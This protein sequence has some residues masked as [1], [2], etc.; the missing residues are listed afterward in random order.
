M[1]KMDQVERIR[2][3]VL[4]KGLSERQAARECRVSR[5]LVRRALGDAE[6]PKYHLSKP[7]PRP[8]LDAVRALVEEMLR[9]DA[10]QPRKQ[11]HTARRIFHR[12]REEH[13]FQGAESSIRRCVA[14]LRQRQPEVFVPLAYDAGSEAQVDF[15]E[16]E[17]V[18]A[19]QRIT[20]Q[21]FCIKL[22]YSHMPFVIAFPHQRQ[23][24]FF[25]GHREAFAFFGGV[26]RRLTYDNLKVAVQ[27]ILEGHDREEQAAFQSLRAHYLF[28]SHFCNPRHG[29]EK[30]QVESLVGYVRRNALVPVPEV[31]SFAELNAHLLRWCEREAERTQPGMTGTIGE[32]LVADRAALLPLPE[33][34]FDCARVVMAKVNRYAQVTYDTCV[35]SVPWQYAHRSATLKAYVDRVEVWVDR[36]K[37]AQHVRCY[38]RHGTVLALDHYLD[39][40][41]R[42]PGALQFAIPF[43]QAILPEAYHKFHSALKYA[44]GP[45]TGD[46]E[47]VR[48]LM[49]L[50]EHAPEDVLWAVTEALE[51]GAWYADAVR[52][53]LV[54]RSMPQPPRPLHPDEF[55]NMPVLEIPPAGI[56][57]FNRLLRKGGTVH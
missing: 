38:E 39:V 46:K 22:C 33:R 18:M 5:H 4:T 29:N 23:E 27:R 26:P 25:E 1:I 57:H 43:K 3:L 12:L 32:H 45:R 8:V 40:F 24:A 31:A 51:R 28:D 52:S 21:L 47:F 49:L 6:P 14:E 54:M 9:S 48:V 20:V 55:M 41:L 35:Y 10:G 13:G 53:L 56:Q 16:A 15:G 50:R 42:K 17:V 7:R 36:E 30:G 37:V 19:G 44:N 34:P 11:R 2:K